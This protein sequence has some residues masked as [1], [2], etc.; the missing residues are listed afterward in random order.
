MKPNENL[1]LYEDLTT[2]ERAIRDAQQHMA[3]IFTKAQE[4]EE[5]N[6]RLEKYL[7]PKELQMLELLHQ[8]IKPDQNQNQ[9]ILN[10]DTYTI[11]NTTRFMQESTKDPTVNLQMEIQKN[12]Q[13]HAN[14]N[15]VTEMHHLSTNA[16]VIDYTEYDPKNPP[17]DDFARPISLTTLN[18]S[19]TQQN[20]QIGEQ[21]EMM[22]QIIQN[23]ILVNNTLDTND[24][25]IINMGHTKTANLNGAEILYFMPIQRQISQKVIVRT[26]ATFEDTLTQET[27]ENHEKMRIKGLQV[28]KAVLGQFDAEG[29]RVGIFIN[30]TEDA[31]ISDNEYEQL[32]EFARQPTSNLVLRRVSQN[33]SFSDTLGIY[34][35]AAV[36]APAEAY[37]RMKTIVQHEL[38]PTAKTFKTTV[39]N[40]LKEDGNRSA[41]FEIKFPKDTNG[42]IG[43]DFSYIKETT[44]IG[45]NCILVPERENPAEIQTHLE[46]FVGKLTQQ[47]TT[48]LIS[49]INDPAQYINEGKVPVQKIQTTSGNFEV[50]YNQ[51][52]QINGIKYRAYMVKNQ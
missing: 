46:E 5:T 17:K 8:I 42:F 19:R 41:T 3:E 15:L 34:S 12:G 31:P 27:I 13:P 50:S 22:F 18:Y 16:N 1:Y 37:S 30:Q 6:K 51:V 14:V 25:F 45:F 7:D 49:L 4:E 47:D 52:V 23:P 26:L 44:K 29:N 20:G 39:N 9:V 40:V 2:Q 33:Y 11:N 28:I 21:N 35:G 10:G 36:F 48:E 24:Y 32:F 38:N 43:I